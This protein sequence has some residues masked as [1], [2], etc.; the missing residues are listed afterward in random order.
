MDFDEEPYAEEKTSLEVN[1]DIEIKGQLDRETLKTVYSGIMR[2]DYYSA[3]I[4]LDIHT[5]LNQAG[6]TGLPKP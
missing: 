1:V 2:S 5:S 4:I 3:K 6:V